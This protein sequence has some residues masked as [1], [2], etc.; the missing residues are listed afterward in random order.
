MFGV[1]CVYVNLDPYINIEAKAFQLTYF[2]GIE[3][4]M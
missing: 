2:Q 3:M 4:G 1:L